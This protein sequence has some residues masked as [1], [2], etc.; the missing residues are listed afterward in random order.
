MDN[1]VPSKQKLDL[2]DASKKVFLETSFNS[3]L[4]NEEKFKKNKINGVSLFANVG[5]AETY[6]NKTNINIILANEIKK[7]RALFYRD[8]YPETNMILGDI[9]HKDV[10]LNLLQNATENNCEFVLATPPCQGMSVAG[11]MSENDPRNFLIIQTVSFLNDLNPKYAIIENVPGILKTFLKINDETVKIID[12]IKA[13]LKNYNIK[14]QIMDSS[15]FEIPQ[16]RK[17]AIFLISRKDV[18]ELF[19]PEKSIKKITVKDA[20]GCLPTLESGEKSS[21][22]YHNAKE[23]NLRQ[24]LAMRHTPTGKTALDNKKF[25]PKKENGEKVKGYATTYKRI[26]WDKP[27]PTITMANGSISSQNN[28]HPGRLKKDGT[29]SDARVLTL[30]EIFILTGLPD[31]WEPPAWSSEN[32]IRQVIGEGIPPKLLLEIVKQI[33]L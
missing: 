11:K 3:V 19:F 24:I 20:I 29:Y 14:Y 25:F 33:K 27:A 21:I 23:H 7:K 6:F 30:K 17:R 9:T 18:P 4:K 31:D 15:D 5:I 32:L 22:R 1:F 8:M 16:V 13:S 10:Y 28:V 2:K 26:D 12:Y